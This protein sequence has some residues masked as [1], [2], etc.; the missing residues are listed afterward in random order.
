MNISIIIIKLKPLSGK[1]RWSDK[2]V[3]D[4]GSRTEKGWNGLFEP[5]WNFILERSHW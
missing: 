2:P 3:L 5:R 1:E 4:R